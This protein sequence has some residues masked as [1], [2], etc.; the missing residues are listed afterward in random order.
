[1]NLSEIAR[2][3][4]DLMDRGSQKRS[5]LEPGSQE[6]MADSLAPLD[7]NTAGTPEDMS[8]ASS[9]GAVAAVQPQPP[10]APSSVPPIPTP[11]KSA[12]ARKN[13]NAGA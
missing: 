8:P 4:F 3:V 5:P 9:R 10:G 1:M 11:A 13:A 6:A 2:I 7:G 12:L